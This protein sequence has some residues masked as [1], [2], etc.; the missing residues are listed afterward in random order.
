[1]WAGWHGVGVAVREAERMAD[2]KVKAGSGVAE[3]T[4]VAWTCLVRTRWW[5]AWTPPPKKGAKFG[6]RFVG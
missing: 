1:M 6:L 4:T 5:F 2:P 3:C